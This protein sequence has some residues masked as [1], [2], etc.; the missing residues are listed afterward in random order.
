MSARSS[1]ATALGVNPVPRRAGR[2]QLLPGCEQIPPSLADRWRLNVNRSHGIQ[3]RVYVRDPG[4]ESRSLVVLGGQISKGL[5]FAGVARPVFAPNKFLVKG[6]R[7][8]I[9]LL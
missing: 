1:G 7:I 3:N 9:G 2:P 4:W 5:G 6:L 8:A